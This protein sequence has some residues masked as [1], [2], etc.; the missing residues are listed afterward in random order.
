MLQNLKQL[1]SEQ[2]VLFF[3]FFLIVLDVVLKLGNTVT[4]NHYACGF[5]IIKA[6]GNTIPIC[7]K[8]PCCSSNIRKLSASD[9]FSAAVEP[10]TAAMCTY[11]E[12]IETLKKAALISNAECVTL[13]E[14]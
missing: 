11:W 12:S 3:F 4:D 14:R 2:R 8:G 6:K 10:N 13:Q 7:N 5:C 9:E 1:K